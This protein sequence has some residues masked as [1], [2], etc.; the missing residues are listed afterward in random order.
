MSFLKYLMMKSKDGGGIRFWGIIFLILIGISVK[1]PPFSVLIIGILIR[2]YQNYLE[3]ISYVDDGDAMQGGG[4][5]SKLLKKILP[6]FYPVLAV[7][8]IIFANWSIQNN[9]NVG[10]GIVGIFTI[11]FYLLFYSFLSKLKSTVERIEGEEEEYSFDHK[12]D[13]VEKIKSMNLKKWKVLNKRLSTMEE[14]SD[15]A[16]EMEVLSQTQNAYVAQEFPKN[17]N[18]KLYIKPKEGAPNLYAYK[19]SKPITLL[20]KEYA[21]RVKAEYE[22]KKASDRELIG[23]YKK[24][25]M[26]DSSREQIRAHIQQPAMEGVRQSPQEQAWQPPNATPKPI[27]EHM[28]QENYSQYRSELKRYEKKLEKEQ[29]IKSQNAWFGVVKTCRVCGS[30]S[31]ISRNNKQICE[32]CG[33]ETD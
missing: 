30:K 16:R 7:G 1:F 27:L 24:T 15:F 23:A 6:V 17:I 12:R 9:T 18:P 26:S 25:Q 33:M 21:D 11:M 3:Y 10:K 2:Q 32:F 8:F 19:G 14:G 4:G 22:L 29:K 28:D 20:D 13:S 31:K 5:F